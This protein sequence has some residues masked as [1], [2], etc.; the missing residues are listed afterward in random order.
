MTIMKNNKD[1]KTT[2]MGLLVCGILL[3]FLGFCIILL[4]FAN[5]EA[6]IAPLGYGLIGLGG[7]SF[8]SSRFKIW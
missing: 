5:D 1:M 3:F 7:L 4:G 8:I 2:S 6:L